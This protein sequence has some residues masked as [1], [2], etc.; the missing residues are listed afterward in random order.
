MSETDTLTEIVSELKTLSGNESVSATYEG[1]HGHIAQ[2]SS[3]TD[4]QATSNNTNVLAQLLETQ[5][6]ISDSKSEEISQL[7]V[8]ESQL[9]SLLETKD[10]VIQQQATKITDLLETIKDKDSEIRSKDQV[11]EQ[12]SNQI[13][14]QKVEIS[15]LKAT[16][17]ELNK[18]MQFM[19][20]GVKQNSVWLRQNEG[21]LNTTEDGTIWIP[22][23]SIPHK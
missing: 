21:S 5:I 7:K 22:Y 8:V 10:D 2:V 1:V 14:E 15:K 23:S 11:I 3:K 18:M 12:K 16:N 17:S 20:E 4:G 9:Q 6:N 19:A 13:D